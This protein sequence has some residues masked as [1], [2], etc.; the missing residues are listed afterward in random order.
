MKIIGTNHFPS[1][2]HAILYYESYGI[3]CEEIGK[4]LLNQEIK[5]GKPETKDGEEIILIDGGTRYAITEKE[6]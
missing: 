2:G 4:K 5:F 3:S 6:K 1:L